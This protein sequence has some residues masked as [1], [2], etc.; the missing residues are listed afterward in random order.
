MVG[1]WFF[2]FVQFTG[3]LNFIERLGYIKKDGWAVISRELAI[4]YVKRY[5]WWIAEWFLRKP[6][7]VCETIFT[8]LMKRE[9]CFSTNFSQSFAKRSRRLIRRYEER[10]SI[11]FCGFKINASLVQLFLAPF[12]HVW[13]FRSRTRMFVI[14]NRNKC[15]LIIC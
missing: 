12:F 11:G 3:V 9:I 1:E 15:C 6:I 14:F 8:S 10:M 5:I 4:K 13:A 7:W 2:S